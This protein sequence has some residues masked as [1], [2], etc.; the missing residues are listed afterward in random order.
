VSIVAEKS[1]ARLR[2]WLDRAAVA[3]SVSDVIDDPG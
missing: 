1:P 2:R 3:A